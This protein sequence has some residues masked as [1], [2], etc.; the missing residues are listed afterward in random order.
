MWKRLLSLAVLSGILLACCWGCSNNTA[1]CSDSSCESGYKCVN[2]VCTLQ[3]PSGQLEC[4]SS[5]V[6]VKVDN[7]HCG[8]CGN[9]CSAGLSC[10][11]GVCAC[12]SGTI[13]SGTLP[14]DTTSKPPGAFDL[15]TGRS[16]LEP[17][18]CINS[19]ALMCGFE[20]SIEAIVS[21]SSTKD[22]PPPE[23][24]KLG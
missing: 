5:C 14:G 9:S 10:Q 12:S 2:D 21:L 15:N 13:S 3:C 17:K 22:S 18:A 1:T 8:S 20:A 4:Q 16:G 6:D 19:S 11:E 7:L 23:E 24:W